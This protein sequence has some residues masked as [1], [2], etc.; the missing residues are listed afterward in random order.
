MNNKLT[1]TIRPWYRYSWPWMLMLGPFTA[2]VAGI[3]TV[4]LAVQSYDGLVDDDYYKQG[5][6]VNQV[7]ERDQN[8]VHL[9]LQAELMQSAETGQ[10]R[11]FL[12]G[13]TTTRLPD[14]LK[15]KIAHP[16]RAGV[17]QNMII[18]AEADG[19]YT[20]KL[21]RVLAGRWHVTIED[22]NNDW[23]LTGSWLLDKEPIL[24]ITA[25]RQER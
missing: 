10:I 14:A 11:V 9:G 12:R 7:T 5:L 17:D 19:L 13:N 24:R 25:G 15:L 20:G 16:T 22:E 21:D 8:A 1:E 2:V 3:V 18:R 4:Y 6:A 23:R